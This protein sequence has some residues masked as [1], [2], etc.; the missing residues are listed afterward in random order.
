MIDRVGHKLIER[1]IEWSKEKGG[2]LIYTETGRDNER[3]IRLYQRHGFRTSGIIPDYYQEGR[4][5]LILV[6]K[7]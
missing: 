2:R 3:A 7:L 5:V 6:R 1:C 4:D